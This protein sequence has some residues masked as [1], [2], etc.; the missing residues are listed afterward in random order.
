MVPTVQEIIN[1]NTIDDDQL[2]MMFVCCHPSLCAEAQVSLILK[3]RC[4]FRVA[5]IANAFVSNHDTIEKRLYRA[6]QSFR[7]NH[8]QFELPP[9][10]ELN[11][12]MENVLMATY[13]LF[14]EGY[15]ATQHDELIRKALMEEALRLCELICRS[16]S[17]NHSNAHALMALIF[18][19][20]TRNQARQDADG[21]ILL[22]KQQDIT[23]WN[24]QLIQKRHSS[25]GSICGR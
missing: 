20:A 24:K 8:V 11:N 15:N 25:P 9:T 18:F 19:T 22:L 16:P 13:L 3:T 12:R 2:R 14:N 1:T 23:N 10:V 5:E 17:V 6:R 7:D 4:G 21:N